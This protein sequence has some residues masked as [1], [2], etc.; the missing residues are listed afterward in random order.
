MP[1][2]HHGLGSTY[3]E[4]R[5]RSKKRA[6]LVFLHGGPGGNSLGQRRLFPLSNERK[7]YI[8]DQLGSG[9]SKAKSNHPRW[10]IPLFVDELDALIRRWGLDEFH[11]GGGSWGATLALEYYLRK[12][13]KGVTS[14]TF[15]SP[16]FSAEVWAKD[17]KALVARLP[18]KT[19][20]IIL[21]CEK[22]G[23]TDSR[24]YKEAEKEFNKRHVYR[25]KESRPKI[26]RFRNQEIYETMWGPSEFNPIGTL[27]TYDRLRDLGKIRVPTH[28]LCGQYDEA[29]PRSCGRFSRLIKGS[30]LTVLKGCSHRSLAEKPRLVIDRLRVWL[31]RADEA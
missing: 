31:R 12:H 15:I 18:Q 16:M 25:G 10:S 5:G 22:I 23:A 4:T 27:K 24:V 30:K 8:Y 28:I 21:L 1:Y 19:R 7:I 29:T 2:V 20:D 14:L 26:Q 3:Y 17:A 11:L 6:P 9:H 13:G